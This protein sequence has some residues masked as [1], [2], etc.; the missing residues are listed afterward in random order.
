[1]NKRQEREYP[2]NNDRKPSCHEDIDHDITHGLTAHDAVDS[3][4]TLMDRHQILEAIT[5]AGRTC[6]QS[7]AQHEC[8]LEN[9]HEH[10]R[11]DEVTITSC[12]IE[13]WHIGK[14][15]RTRGNEILTV[16]IVA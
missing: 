14:V 4:I 9:Q 2:R 11:D 13:D 12:R 8:L 7:D 3:P 16:G 5:L 10:A 6:C 1:M 15:E